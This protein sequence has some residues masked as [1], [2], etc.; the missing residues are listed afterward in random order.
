MA[1]KKKQDDKESSSYQLRFEAEKK[2]TRS[3][4]KTSTLKKQDLDKLVHELQVHQVE[5]EMQNEELRRT[6]EE[7]DASK[8]RYFELYDVAPV[9][10]FSISEKGIILEANL[11][12]ANLFGAVPR[13]MRSQPFTRF[14]FKEDQDIYYL[15]RQQL[16]KTL[17]P[18][19]CEMRM[20]RKD[21][22][23]FWIQIQ[24]TVA[25][26]ATSGKPVCLATMSDITRQK[27]AED[28]RHIALEKYR[29]LFESFPL[30]IAITDAAGNIVEANKES[31]RLLGLTRDEHLQRRYDGPEWRI[32]RPDGTPMLP[33]E[34]A[35]VRA[36][37]E[38]RRIEN[39]EMG[40]VKRG[41]EIIWINVTAEPI[42]LKD[43]GVAITYS[44]ITERKLAAEAIRASEERFRNMA[45]LLPQAVFETDKDG[46]LTFL[47]RQGF[48][49]FG[50]SQAD[51]AAGVS[52]SELIIPE[53][54]E[55][56]ANNIKQRLIDEEFP[57]QEYTAIRKD[58][59]KFPAAIYTT[60]VILNSEY[61][62]LRGMII[63]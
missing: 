49:M 51:V 58:G 45:N 43:F 53:D 39:V 36:L 23:L 57:S 25:Q 28:Q 4:G 12:G 5:L 37:R 19:V 56:A 1:V 11:T 46:K 8:Q 34:Y 17:L 10:Y 62:G 7:L 55:R 9:G 44:D 13:D 31:E 52:N 40:I 54:R 18:Q 29:V 48:K 41:N 6:Q 20:V 33:D 21:G 22:S 50:Y 61:A 63:D 60:P 3:A 2:V 16:L 59:S 38:N 32:I 42:L 35:S 27:Q 15:H 26:N 47:N 14:I 30:G 24:A